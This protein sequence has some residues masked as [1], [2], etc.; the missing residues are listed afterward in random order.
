MNV[1]LHERM[2]VISV[3]EWQ[4]WS[5]VELSVHEFKELGN[6]GI[7]LVGSPETVIFFGV[8]MIQ[9]IAIMNT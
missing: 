2:D 1:L 6:S 5:T 4:N 7:V 9:Y 8:F 3:K